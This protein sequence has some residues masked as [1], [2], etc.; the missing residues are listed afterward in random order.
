MV[1]LSS[2]NIVKTWY[3]R[4][5]MFTLV[6]FA[7]L[8]RARVAP[9]TRRKARAISE[10][11][12]RFLAK[13]ERGDERPAKAPPPSFKGDSRLG[14]EMSHAGATANARTASAETANVYTTMLP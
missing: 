5:P 13:C 11:T 1:G 6:S 14:L 10:T 8:R 2:T 7:R 9:A 3:V 12:R 4:K